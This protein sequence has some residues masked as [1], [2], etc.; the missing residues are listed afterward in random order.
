[1]AIPQELIAAASLGLKSGSAASSTVGS[2]YSSATKRIALDAQADIADIN[3][4]IA[5][6]G[7]QSELQRGQQQVAALTLQS[8]Q[9]KSRQKVALAA[10]G[11]DIG[12]GSAAEIQASTDIMKDIDSNTLT[13]NAIR[14]AWGYR[15]QAVSMQ[16]EATSLRATS[17]AISPLL[18]A[19]TTLLGG[20]GSVASS[21]YSMSKNGQLESDID[22]ANKTSDPVGSLIQS[23]GW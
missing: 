9:V 16:N 6:L 1:M 2:Y 3:A 19:G 13:A 8:G 7:A 10:N 14:S 17:S 22:K 15:T 12:E 20:A 18:D 11:V 21:W 23:R 4:R 5:E